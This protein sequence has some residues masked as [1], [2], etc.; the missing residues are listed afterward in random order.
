MLIICVAIKIAFCLRS[1]RD[2]AYFFAFF[3]GVRLT[4]FAALFFAGFLAAGFFAFFG[5][6]FFFGF[7]FV[8]DGFFAFFGVDFFFGA[9]FF[10]GFVAFFAAGFL[11]VAFFF[12]VFGAFLASGAKRKVP[13]W[14]AFATNIP[15]ARARLI[16]MRR[17]TF[18]LSPTL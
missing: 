16:A 7:V 17:C 18:A 8:A 12:G 5:V 2:D 14:F 10:F 13:A 9:T 1:F 11:A 15:E 6:D 4:F 3:A